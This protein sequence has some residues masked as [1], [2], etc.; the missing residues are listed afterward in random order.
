MNGFHCIKGYSIGHWDAGRR[1]K[2]LGIVWDVLRGLW[3]YLKIIMGCSER[4]PKG[5]KGKDPDG[6]G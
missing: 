6:S 1:E 5:G 3:E 4:G 2:N